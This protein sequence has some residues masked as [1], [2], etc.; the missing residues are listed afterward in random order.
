MPCRTCLSPFKTPPLQE[1][2]PAI[3]RTGEDAAEEGAGPVPGKFLAGSSPRLGEVCAVESRHRNPIIQ[4]GRLAELLRDIGEQIL[5]HLP[6]L[7]EWPKNESP[8]PFLSPREEEDDS[9]GDK[10][11]LRI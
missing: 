11:F 3:Q 7:T 4:D 8:K 1:G 6:I 10:D 9:G 5:G 2:P